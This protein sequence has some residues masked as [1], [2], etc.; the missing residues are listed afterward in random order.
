MM[1]AITALLLPYVL[2]ERKSNRLF[3]AKQVLCCQGM[4]VYCLLT[5]EIL[6]F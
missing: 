3:Y 1:E 4:P 5:E 6:V 2:E